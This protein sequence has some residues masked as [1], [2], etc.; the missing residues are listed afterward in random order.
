MLFSS[1]ITLCSSSASDLGPGGSGRSPQ[2]Q[3]PESSDL[4]GCLPAEGSG[5]LG[6]HW[7]THPEQP[8]GHVLTAQ[9]SVLKILPGRNVSSVLSDG[10][11]IS[12][13]GILF[14]VRLVCLVLFRV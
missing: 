12:V 14:P 6:R 1:A 9:V 4:H 10:H 2:H 11:V 5:P 3:K 8:A 7:H 13:G